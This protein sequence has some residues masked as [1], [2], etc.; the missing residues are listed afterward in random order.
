[1]KNNMFEGPVI[2]N[3]LSYL[4]DRI[5]KISQK[6]LLIYLILIFSVTGF[7]YSFPKLQLFFEGS[8]GPYA[9]FVN[10]Q[11]KN[12]FVKPQINETAADHKSKR[13]NRITMPMIGH[14]F[15][16]DFRGLVILQQ[17]FGLAFIIIVFLIFQKSFFDRNL[18][19]YLSVIFGSSFAGKCF[20]GT[21]RVFLMALLY[22][23]FAWQHTSA[24]H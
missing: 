4:D 3:V 11:I 9:E 12:P 21:R 19:F 8:C 6:N 20:F 1:M 23:F 14:V 13:F 18:S 17:I 22:F 5:E 2:L 10:D 24:H 7:L 15:K 16:L